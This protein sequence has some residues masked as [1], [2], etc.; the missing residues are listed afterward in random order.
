VPLRIVL[1]A[2]IALIPAAAI[3]PVPSTTLIRGARVFDGSGEAP[4][5]RDVLIRGDR[6]ARVAD[7]I[8]TAAEMV[9]EAA[10]MT[11]L[12]GLVDLHVHTPRDAFESAAGFAARYD[13]FVRRGVTGL[14][15]FSVP[16]E[17]VGRARQVA[18]LGP[19]VRLAIRI[20]VPGGHGS[21]SEWTEPLTT[22]V[23]DPAEAREAVR[24]AAALRPDMIKAFADGW[25]YGREG[26]LASMDAA[27]LE[28]LATEARRAGLP[29]MSHT[30]TSAGLKRAARARLNAVAHGV[31]DAAI[32]DEAI[33]LMQRARMGYVP[34][35]A[36]YEP[37]ATRVLT[38]AE[39]QDL[40]E[41]ARQAEANRRRRPV[42]EWEARRWAVML[43]NVRRVHAAGLTIGLGTDA[44]V[45]GVYPG[46]ASLHELRLLSRAGLSPAEALAAATRG[47]ARIMD[48]T[49]GGRVRRGARADL[50]LVAGRPDETLDALYAIRGVW[51]SGRQVVGGA[52]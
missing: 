50:L 1:A 34:T 43:D 11:L 17:L 24:A 28:A 2:L 44:G 38:A 22:N 33:R 21:E 19:R 32:D 27:T 30:V 12:P 51:V 41:A 36:A 23:S 37:L 31:G 6:V 52:R 5:V 8:G 13:P 49:R 39:A 42:P 47:S 9:V 7:R 15:E 10:G 45:T 26:D 40:P 20:G 4:R 18:G 35:L 46:W 25:R 48:D 3:A 14:N 29:V 16:P